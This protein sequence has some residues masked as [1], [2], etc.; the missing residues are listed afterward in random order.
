MCNIIEAHSKYDVYEYLIP[1]Q[2][3]HYSKM[4]GSLVMEG[5]LLAGARCLAM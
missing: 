3:P 2:C 1:K 4:R 5:M